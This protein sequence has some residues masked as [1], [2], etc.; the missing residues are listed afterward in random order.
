MHTDLAF[1][2]NFLEWNFLEVS[3]DIAEGIVLVIS[4]P[5]MKT[6]STLN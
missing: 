3:I 6:V 5:I 4:W 1:L 2:V